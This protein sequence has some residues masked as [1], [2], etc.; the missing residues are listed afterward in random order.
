MFRHGSGCRFFIPLP[1]PPTLLFLL[2][3]TCRTKGTRGTWIYL[4]NNYCSEDANHCFQTRC[5]SQRRF[6]RLIL[7]LGT[8]YVQ[9][10]IYHHVF[11]RTT[12]LG[13]PPGSSSAGKDRDRSFYSERKFFLDTRVLLPGS[14]LPAVPPS[15]P[16]SLTSSHPTACHKSPRARRAIHIDE[17]GL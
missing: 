17:P 5:P 6:H 10:K 7:F 13:S 2:Q 14:K 8:G 9:P 16:F 1:C 11:P 3:A 15:L 12:S 4:N